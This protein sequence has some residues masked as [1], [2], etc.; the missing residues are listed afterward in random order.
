M[1]AIIAVLTLVLSQSAIA[2]EFIQYDNG[3]TAWRN[4]NGVVYGNSGGGQNNGSGYNDV[5]TGERYENI[6]P[7]Q[8]I[9]TRTGQVINDNHSYDNSSRDDR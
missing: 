1:K 9:N 4:D 8:S 3:S 6:N 5:K 7:N 2:D